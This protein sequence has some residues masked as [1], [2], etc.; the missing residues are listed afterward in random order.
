MVRGLD[1]RNVPRAWGWRVMKPL[2]KPAKE[3]QKT[4]AW[5]L[6]RAPRALFNE[7]RLRPG[8]GSV[9]HA[10]SEAEERAWWTAWHTVMGLMTGAT[11]SRNAIESRKASD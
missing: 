11:C 6:E 1:G 2:S 3:G 5:L 8:S 4:A 7:Y 9:D 10:V